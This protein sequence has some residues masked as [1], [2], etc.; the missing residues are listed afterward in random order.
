MRRLNCPLLGL[1]ALPLVTTPAGAQVATFTT[2]VRAAI[3][4]ALQVTPQRDLDFGNVVQG[5]PETI[6]VTAGGA[7]RLRIRGQSSTPIL[8][9]FTLPANL[10]SGP[11]TM[12][13]DSWTGRWN[14]SAAPGGGTSFTPSGAATSATLSN[15][16]GQVFVYLGARVVPSGT[17]AAGLYAATVTLTVAYP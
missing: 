5:V 8:M 9:T 1:L 11:N 15:G 12:P 4:Q 3:V 14:T 6:A 2:T 16:A 13:I 17:Q 10:V 7:G